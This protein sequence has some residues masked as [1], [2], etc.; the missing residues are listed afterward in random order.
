MSHVVDLC[1][2]G[3]QVFR[4]KADFFLNIIERLDVYAHIGL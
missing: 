1:M 3:R 4:A 2:I